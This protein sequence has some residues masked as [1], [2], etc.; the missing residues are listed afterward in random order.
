MSTGRSCPS[1]PWFG[2]NQAAHDPE[3]L[4]G[5]ISGIWL[6]IFACRCFFSRRTSRASGSASRA[7]M[8]A[9][10]STSV[11]RTMKSLRHYR[12]V[13]H[14]LVARMLVQ[15]RH[16]GAVLLFGGIYA[17]GTFDWGPLP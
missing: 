17:A 3:R 12:N 7:A 16:D 5:P 15:R 8:R 13:G 6:L 14:Y 4:S 11:W 10:A 2:V 9:A 1:H